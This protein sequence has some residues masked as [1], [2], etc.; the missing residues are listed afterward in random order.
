MDDL[1]TFIKQIP[2][3]TRYYL[4]SMLLM[5]L[6]TTYKALSPYTLLLDFEKVFYSCHLWR[7]ITCFTFAGTF[8]FPFVMKMFIAHF[9]VRDLEEEYKEKEYAEFTLLVVFCGLAGMVLSFLYGS[10]MLLVDPFL[11]SLLY[12]KC[13]KNPEQVVRFWGIPV[14]SAHF[15]WA[16]MLF[17]MLMGAD[18]VID[19]IGIGAGHSYIFCKEVLPRSHGYRPLQVPM[20]LKNLIQR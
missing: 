20:W 3:F 9:S 6:L 4:G 11:T 10:H 2:G 12:I 19:L 17:H 16:F 13:M 15:P 8:G 14:K 1:K 7:L 5:A 18:P